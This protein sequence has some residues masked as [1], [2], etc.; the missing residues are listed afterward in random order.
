M[1]EEQLFLDSGAFGF[2]VAPQGPV[3]RRLL[4]AHPL[5]EE[6]KNAHRF[7]VEL[8]RE[9][10]A[11][12]IAS[13]ILDCRGWGD[14]RGEIGSCEAMAADCDLAAQLLAQ[15]FPES[16]L[17]FIGVRAASLLPQ[18]M[19]SQPARTALIDPV[20]EGELYIDEVLKTTLVR[21]MMTAGS[22]GVSMPQLREK[23]ASEGVDVDGIFFSPAFAATLMEAELNSE[24]DLIVES[25][26]R[27]K[28][29]PASQ[30]LGRRVE[31]IAQFPFWK[32]PDRADFS[33]YFSCLREF[34][35]H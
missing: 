29:S 18:L 33:P 19:Q 25:T 24:V 31:L 9:L 10:A 23:L 30:R 14:A 2:L 32:A 20:Y 12:G 34:I 11:D 27:K 28:G 3:T 15:R 7:Y 1:V 4:L 26:A 21:A 6:K 35:A 8:A 17:L 16:D 5:F 13:F 22:S